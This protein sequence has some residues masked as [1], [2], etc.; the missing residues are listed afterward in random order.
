LVVLQRLATHLHLVAQQHL[1]EVRHS[2]VARCLAVRHSLVPR[3]CLELA[4]RRLRQQ[5]RRLAVVQCS[6]QEMA[7]GM[8]LVAYRV[9]TD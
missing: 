9:L 4:H 3:Q 1:V 7:E 2:E 8:Q 6:D 5:H